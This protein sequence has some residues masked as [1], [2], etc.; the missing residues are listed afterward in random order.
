MPLSTRVSC[1]ER[2]G[3]FASDQASVR[4]SNLAEGGFACPR[5]AV[6]SSLSCLSSRPAH[7][8][9]L[10][11][12]SPLLSGGKHPSALPEMVRKR[13]RFRVAS[14][15]SL[16][17]EV[18]R[19]LFPNPRVSGQ[20]GSRPVTRLERPAEGPESGPR[21]QAGPAAYP[22]HPSPGRAEERTGL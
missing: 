10:V 18:S 19:S 3:Q 20:L 9:S 8:G 1:C 6:P 16:Q 7:T 22:R 17:A 21:L 2:P 12:A 5:W 11:H 4:I 14:G 15:P 13:A